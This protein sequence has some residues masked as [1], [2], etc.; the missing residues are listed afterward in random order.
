MRRRTFFRFVGVGAAVAALPVWATDASAPR[1]PRRSS[2][3]ASLDWLFA[4][5]LGRGLTGGHRVASVSDVD[6]GAITITLVHT[7][8]SIAPVHVFRR[9]PLSRGLATTNLLDLRL[10]NGADGGER[11]THE[12]LGVAVLT[13]AAHIR[14]I[15][16]A[17]LRAGAGLGERRASLRRL[18]SHEQRYALHGGFAVVETA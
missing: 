13:L 10:M 18:S 15:E 3:V 1:A 17:A 16:T 12:E 2:D 6:R 11:A 7:D 14:R 9:S 8:G 4:G 5:I